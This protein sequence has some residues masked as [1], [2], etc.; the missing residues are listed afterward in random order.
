[1]SYEVAGPVLRR[2]S[3]PDISFAATMAFL[4]VGLLPIFMFVRFWLGSGLS[5]AVLAGLL[6]IEPA[7]WGSSLVGLI[8]I[9]VSMVGSAG[10][11]ERHRCPVGRHWL[12]I[13]RSPASGRHELI[14]YACPACPYR[15]VDRVARAAAGNGGWFAGPG[16]TS[17]SGWGGGGRQP[18]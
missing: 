8:G 7:V 3:E 15:R 4:V 2:P 18:R 12:E 10:I 6:L 1:M 13:T 9:A 11:A 17:G 5:G 16:W 14:T